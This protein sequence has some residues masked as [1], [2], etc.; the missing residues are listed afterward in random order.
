M[1][2]LQDQAPGECVIKDDV[3]KSLKKTARLVNYYP[4]LSR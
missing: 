3:A 1:P 4:G 2:F